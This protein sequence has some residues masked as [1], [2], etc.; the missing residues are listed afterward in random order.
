[1]I[2]CIAAISKNNQIGINNQLP[3][4]IPEDLQ[5]F[6]KL[7]TGKTVIMGRKT[8]ESIGKPLPNRHN[9]VLTHQTHFNVDSSVEVLHSLDDALSLCKRLNE[10]FI[11]GGGQ[12]YEAFLPY[13]DRLYLTLVDLT[14]KG[15]TA[16]PSFKQD[17]TCVKT[18]LGQPKDPESPRYTFTVWTR[19]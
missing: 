9:V 15:D 16:F 14:I 17:F 2:N 8:Y 12:L 3:W 19:S 5:Y 4:H 6:K 13:T 10:V 18:T 7:T 11:I 1:M